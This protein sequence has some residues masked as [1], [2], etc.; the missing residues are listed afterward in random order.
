MMLD[1]FFALRRF[2]VFPHHFTDQLLEA[3]LQPS[4]ARI[5]Q[6]GLDFDR[7]EVFGV[8]SDDGLAVVVDDNFVNA[9]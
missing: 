2:Q 5:A 6:K 7:A 8:D 9:G 4:L 3:D 1:E